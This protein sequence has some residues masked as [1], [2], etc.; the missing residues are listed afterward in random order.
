MLALRIGLFVTLLFGGGLAA[1]Q[2]LPL[3]KIID[4]LSGADDV[5]VG[6]RMAIPDEP[7]IHLRA[8]EE[9][10]TASEAGLDDLHESDHAD[11]YATPNVI[12]SCT[13]GRK[14]CP[15]VCRDPGR[16]KKPK[17]TKPGDV[18]RGDCPPYRY[19]ISDHHRAG[20]PH[21]VACWAKCGV[22]DK[23]SAWFVGG[24]AAFCRGRCRK[25]TEGTWGLDYDGL[26]GHVNN[27]LKYTRGREQGG[28]GSYATDGEPE[29][30][31]RIH[32]VFGHGH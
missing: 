23:Y 22:S 9:P 32:G 2:D 21:R 24:G 3:R 5:A 18:D 28:E 14:H 29:F 4:P 13:C 25:P 8:F 19:Q 20:N 17:C 27:W 31:S 11:G 7:E 10:V 26:F 16:P 15:G 1:A 30:V 12:G 6:Q